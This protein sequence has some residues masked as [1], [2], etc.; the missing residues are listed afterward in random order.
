[1]VEEEHLELSQSTGAIGKVGDVSDSVFATHANG[2][3]S[4]LSKGAAIYAGDSIQTPEGASAGFTFAD[5]TVLSLGEKGQLTVSEFS[6]DPATK[7]GTFAA[8]ISEGQFSFVSGNIAKTSVNAMSITTPVIKI[9]INGT[10]G[11]GK[12]G[13]EGSSNSVSLL[14]NA[15]GSVGEMTVATRAGVVVVNAPGATVAAAN[16]NL[17]PPAPVI[18]S[19]QQIQQAYGA[20]L[21]SLPPPPAV[22]AA[23]ETNQGEGQQGGE[24]GGEAESESEAESEAA[25]ESENASEGQGEA[26]GEAAAEGEAETSGEGEGEQGPGNQGEGEQGEGNQGEGNQGEGNQG[27]G[28]QG[29]GNQGEGCPSS[30]K[31]EQS[32]A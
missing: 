1:V 18:F 22:V 20:A 14:P 19:P 10:K 9:G 11:A 15:D 12:A 28:N 26:E 23:A 31:L 32:P 30:Y 7:E 8:D 4:V 6:Y 16:A 13:P 3:R 27:E 24:G 21:N 25:T 17:P 29:E 5:G 2:E